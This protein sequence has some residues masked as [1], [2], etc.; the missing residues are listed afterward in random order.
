MTGL[1]A[2]IEKDHGA[3][4][5]SID[6]RTLKKGEAYLALKGDRLD[7]HDFVGA[8]FK[9]GAACAIVSNDYKGEGLL[10]H[11]PDTMAALEDLGREG[12]ARSKAKIV[13]VT[14]SAGK[15]GTK[16]M[17]AVALSASGKTHASKKSFNNHWGVPLTL[18]NLPADAVYGIIEMGMNH[19]GEMERLSAMTRPHVAIVTTIE[20]AHIGNF[21]S[22]E[23]IADAKAEIFSAM[24]KGAAAILNIDNPHFARLKVA[25]QKRGLSVISF[26]E[27]DEADSR[28]VD[29][30]LHADSS[31]VTASVMGKQ[32]KYKLNIP[33]K[34]IVMNSLA[35][36]A[37]VRA[38]GASLDKAVDALRDAEPVEGRGVRKPVVIAAGAPP[39]TIIDESYNA[40][41]A[42]M[43]AALGVLEMAE[44][45]GEGR[46][47]A[48]L[49]DMMELG[50]EGP[51]LHA[52]LAN[53]LLKS[54]A[55]LVFCCGPQMDALYSM[56]P[57]PWKGAHTK[58][59]RELA[60]LVA[61]AVRPGDVVLVKGSLGSKMAY[62]VEALQN[63]NIL[64]SKDNRHAL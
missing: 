12:R 6:T 14:G 9:A 41:P 56:L 25:A 1:L 42:S 24:D 59:S 2:R 55:D 64:K 35:A 38:L 44:P 39:L 8:A 29:L 34:H 27:E 17:L 54:R 11:V 49:G 36:L 13:G 5:I 4:G 57:D 21:K 30:T 19:A 61:A 43:A 18:A 20:P 16:E 32:V 22:V 47:I 23:A 37:A 53:P 50:P 62:V 33:G 3:T 46:R 7:G 40:N 60:A 48:V 51:H 58:E 52:A 15:T 45:E 28:L 26:G 63:L 31:R 10:V